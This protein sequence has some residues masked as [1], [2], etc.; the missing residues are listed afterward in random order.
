MNKRHLFLIIFLFSTLGF[1]NP[2]PAEDVFK[3]SVKLTDPNSFSLNWDI[4][5]GFFLYKDRINLKKED[6]T[7]FH[8]GRV[9][10]PK[11]L[12]KI[13]QSGNN[14][15]IYRNNLTLPVAILGESAGEGL[16][17]VNY[18]G[19][20]NAGFCYPPQTKTI[21]LT[22]D[23]NLALTDVNIEEL[24]IE[25]PKNLETP[26]QTDKLA[27]LFASKNWAIIILSF[28]GFGLLLSFTPCV[29]PMVPVLSG[30]IVGHG[31]D[32][33]T[34][35]A[36]LLSL[37]Y[38]FSMSLTYALVGAVVALLGENLQ[39]SMQSPVTVSLFCL[40][41]IMLAFSMFGFYELKLPVSWQAKLAS[42]TRSQ[43]SGHYLSA[44]IMGCLSTL[45]LSPCVT[46]PLIGALT[47]IAQSGNVTLGSLALFFLGLGMGT[48]LLLIGISAG[49]LLPK[50]GLW[51][52]AVKAF[53][54]IMLLAVA[55]Y[56]LSRV[57]PTLVV[58]ILWA[59]L[60]I[61]SGIYIG[62][63]NKAENHFDKFKRALG[64]MLLA[65]GILI[66]IGGAKGNSDPLQP[67]VSTSEIIQYGPSETSIIVKNV[68]ELQKEIAKAK[69]KPIMIDYYADWC[70]SCIEMERTTLQMPEIRSALSNF[71]AIKVDITANNAESKKL[72]NLYK[73][74][75]PP[76]F[77]FID[78]EGNEFN[79]L[80][81][82]GE[83]NHQ[84]F[85]VNLQSALE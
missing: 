81:L 29:L 45:I 84:T 18:Q 1:A 49:K 62:A 66:L 73:V 9:S 60:L 51:M 30:I 7:N 40:I 31:K 39:I 22:I 26:N 53:F 36:F 14:Y 19:C 6:D 38:V 55:I 65:Y 12:K 80:R 83:A 25:S 16:I 15:L 24:A 44:A 71:I 68:T 61:F 35:K 48:P 64:I 67:L 82:V 41:F 58:M 52:N 43:S 42:I 34:K 37:S 85:Y 3:L 57:V 46:A 63:L 33:S 74:V 23:N 10:L 28:F 72:L 8:L 50:A 20:S 32:I 13:N 17:K 5:D 78:K 54:G 21:K 59:S 27:N 79:N 4:K 69:G 76:T 70:I 11:A 56:L 2:P 75:A 47:Y 77:I